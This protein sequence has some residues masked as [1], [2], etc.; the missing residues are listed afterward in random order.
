MAGDHPALLRRLG[1]VIDLRVADP[2]RLLQCAVAVGARVPSTAS[3][4]PA[5]VRVCVASAPATTW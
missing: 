1:L 5:A 4:V 2:A 3:W